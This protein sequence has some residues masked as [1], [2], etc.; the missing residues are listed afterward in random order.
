MT[1]GVVDM[2]MVGGLG[3]EELD[4]SALGNTWIFGT[5]IFGLGM[6]FG[7]D[8]IISQS[9]G[10]GDSKRIALALQRGVVV[11]LLMSVP[12]ALAWA[13][14]DGALNLFGQAEEMSQMAQAYVQIQI[15]SIPTFL[16]FNTL[17]QYL[18]GRGI[19]YPALWIVLVGNA[20]NI[21]ANWLLIYGHW[22][23]PTMGIEGAGLATASTR[24]F[25]LLSLYLW[26]R[27]FHLFDGA[28]LPWSR[29]AL[30]LGGLAEIFHFGLPVALQYGLEGW[31]FQLTTIMAGWLGEVE[32]AAHSISL[33]L[34]SI[35]FM[36]PLGL[37]MGAAT[38]VGNL[39]GQ[40]RFQGCAT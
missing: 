1:L 6:G 8:P 26:M 20:F 21:V 40:G 22:G 3:I 33:N 23:F 14:T 32:L 24:C 30:A 28:W 5:L 16:I 39:I 36:L 2:A 25:L 19:V 27:A 37:S 7:L 11:A 29:E 10:A 38:R 18:Q 35:A 31:A 9:H 12:I 17:R 4:A 13:F 15:F 34:S